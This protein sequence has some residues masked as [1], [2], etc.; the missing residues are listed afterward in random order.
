MTSRLTLFMPITSQ[1]KNYP[2]EVEIQNEEI[3]GA[4]LS[5]QIRSLDW[6]ARKAKKIMRISD[7]LV[8]EVLSKLE[9]LL[10]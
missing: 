8:S 10:E 4:I 6:Q 5:D 1:I 7:K 9:L 3:F 2:F